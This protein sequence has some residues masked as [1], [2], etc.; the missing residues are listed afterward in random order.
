MLWPIFQIFAVAAFSWV[1]RLLSDVIEFAE[2]APPAEDAVE[3][4]Q[5]VDVTIVDES[6]NQEHAHCTNCHDSLIFQPFSASEEASIPRADDLDSL[7]LGE[8]L[9]MLVKL[10]ELANVKD[11]F[12][13]DMEGHGAAGWASDS[14]DVFVFAM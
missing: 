13:P 10:G 2:D 7:A 5:S 12:R 14:A 4:K 8:P 6:G 9:V 1:K 11:L 3:P